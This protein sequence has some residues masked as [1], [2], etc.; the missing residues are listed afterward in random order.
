MSEELSCD[1]QDI[2]LLTQRRRWRCIVAVHLEERE[3]FWLRVMRV[4]DSNKAVYISS[5][6]VQLQHGPPW[7]DAS[8][9]PA[10]QGLF[11]HS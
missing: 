3:G 9:R 11:C 2:V 1:Y 8:L 4:L 6:S 5:S 10:V 7:V